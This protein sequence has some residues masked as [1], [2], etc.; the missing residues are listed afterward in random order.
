MHQPSKRVRFLLAT[1]TV[2][3]SGCKLGEP[4]RKAGHPFSLPEMWASRGEGNV[5]QVGMDWLATLEDPK[6]EALIA[7]ALD[8]NPN[9]K[10]TAS[11]LAA[12][13]QG[14]IIGRAARLPSASTSTSASLSMSTNPAPQPTLPHV[15]CNTSGE[16]KS[17]SKIELRTIPSLLDVLSIIVSSRSASPV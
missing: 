16:L 12:A 8:R 13:E 1:L 14:V 9:L 7:E 10:I 15:R 11:R 4:E 2:I 6:L 5:G 3:A 17:A